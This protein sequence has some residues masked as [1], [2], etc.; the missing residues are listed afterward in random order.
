M[1]GGGNIQYCHF[2]HIMS[3]LPHIVPFVW[4]A[5]QHLSTDTDIASTLSVK[6]KL[7]PPNS[8]LDIYFSLLQSVQIFLL[9]LI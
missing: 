9:Y 2:K 3:H 1:V 8:L 6:Q 5:A 7:T 4:G